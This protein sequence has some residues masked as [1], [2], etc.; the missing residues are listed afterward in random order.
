MTRHPFLESFDGLPLERAKDRAVEQTLET[1]KAEAYETG[2]ASGWDDALASD[3][4]AR[5]KLEA[6]FERNIQ[7][8]ALTFADAVAHVR[9]ELAGLLDAIT[10]QFL[11]DT[12]PNVLR[13]H[14]KSELM[15][16]GDDLTDVP[17]QVVASEDCSTAVFEMIGKEA[18]RNIEVIQDT[19]LAAGQVY[20]RLGRSEV[21]VN[22][23]PLVR[24]ISG[25]LKALT[26]QGSEMGEQDA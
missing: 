8:L 17:I 26:D 9:G 3:K 15:K 22:L 19:T 23:Q 13:E 20:L 5:L 1:A 25:Q 12:A 4:S 16:L 21:E 18:G 14:V 11:P 6:E 10:S 24:A 2:Y 7:C